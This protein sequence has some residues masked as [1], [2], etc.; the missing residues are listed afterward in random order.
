MS[1]WLPHK[2]LSV[3][4]FE[5][6]PHVWRSTEVKAELRP[7]DLVFSWLNP[8]HSLSKDHLSLLEVAMS[9]ENACID[10]PSEDSPWHP[11]VDS[12]LHEETGGLSSEPG[13]LFDDL[14]PGIRTSDT[15]F[16]SW[17]LGE[18]CSHLD[19]VGLAGCKWLWGG[20]GDVDK[21]EVEGTDREI[22]SGD[23]FRTAMD[24]VDSFTCK[25]NRFGNVCHLKEKR[26]SQS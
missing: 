8:K 25:T 1:F 6:I 14:N 9:S 24:S 4:S 10:Q 19:V 11:W 26:W 18:C 12:W 20:S 13:M 21:D 16:V 23:G 22:F 3:N 5:Q 2:D 17:C 15:G 7:L